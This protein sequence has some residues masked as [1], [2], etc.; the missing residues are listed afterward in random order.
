MKTLTPGGPAGSAAKSQQG[1]DTGI[2]NFLQKLQDGPGEQ[3]HQNDMKTPSERTESFLGNPKE[4]GTKRGTRAGTTEDKC[5]PRPQSPQFVIGSDAAAAAGWKAPRS[6]GRGRRMGKG[7][8]GGA[9]AS[10]HCHRRASSVSPLPAPQSVVL[11]EYWPG[12]PH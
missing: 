11:R 8:A 4:T 9:W 7:R 6:R 1:P 2:K 10:A 3:I 12:S 5:V